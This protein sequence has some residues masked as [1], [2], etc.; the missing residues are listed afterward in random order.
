MMGN[1]AGENISNK[2][3]VILMKLGDVPVRDLYVFP[4]ST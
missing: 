1:M 4:I 3:A 2:K